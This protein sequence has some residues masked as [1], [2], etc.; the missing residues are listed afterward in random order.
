MLAKGW[1]AASFLAEVEES[2][3]G[4]NADEDHSHNFETLARLPWLRPSVTPPRSTGGCR[5]PEFFSRAF[6]PPPL[7]P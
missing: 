4:Q 1:S 2:D 7:D 5:S 6:L 3:P